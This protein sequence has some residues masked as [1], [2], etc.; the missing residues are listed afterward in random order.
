M[1]R[2]INMRKETYPNLINL[3]DDFEIKFNTSLRN[4]I[5]KVKTGDT[6]KITKGWVNEYQGNLQLSTGKFG[7]L[8]IV[9]SGSAEGAEVAKDVQEAV[10]EDI[11]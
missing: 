7:Q 9:N 11:I 5:E 10:D 4:R 2:M 1:S 6:I 3:I 8:E